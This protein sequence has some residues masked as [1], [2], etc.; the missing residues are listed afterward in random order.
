[1]SGLF[2]TGQQQNKLFGPT[3][4][5]TTGQ[6]TGAPAGNQDNTEQHLLIQGA[7]EEGRKNDAK[8]EG[9]V[10]TEVQGSNKVKRL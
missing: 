8:G 1:M 4:T 10:H 7:E 5:T 2:S 9:E 3:A 6:T